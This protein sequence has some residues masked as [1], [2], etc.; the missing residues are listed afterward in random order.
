MNDVTQPLIKICGITTES[1]ALMAV[2]MG[3]T[4]L[5]FVFAPSTRQVSS[6]TVRDIVRSLPPGIETVGVFRNEA[7][8]LV[9][10]IVIETGLSM[11]QLHG[12]E[13][14]DE[15]AWVRARAARVIKGLNAASP[16]VEDYDESEADYLLLDGENPGSGEM[17]DW[18]ILGRRALKTP[19]IAA[20]G[21]TPYTVA[22][23][24][25]TLPIVGVDVSTGVESAPGR[26]DPI[27]V[28][29]FVQ[30]T[31][32]GFAERSPSVD[33]FPYEGDFA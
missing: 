32:Q 29:N 8:E 18:G 33:Q 10:S 23:V 15:V 1:D 20:G 7:P 24:T 30:A 31:L 16:R 6:N 11:A 25:R 13:S 22:E 28:K 9:A 2:G 4:A 5:G 14:V 21:L 12:N 27:S 26:K 19:I 3:A 17:H